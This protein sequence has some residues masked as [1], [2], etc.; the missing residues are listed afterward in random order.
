MF[1][2]HTKCLFLYQGLSIINSA[3]VSNKGN[4]SI[5]ISK[6]K[7]GTKIAVYAKDPLKNISKIKTVTVI[8]KTAPTIPK[9]NKVSANTKI[10]TGKA[11]SGAIVYI[12]NGNKLVKNGTVD[13]K[14]NIRI[15]IAKQKKGTA[16]TV[17][18][19]DKAGNKSKIRLVKVS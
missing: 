17:F 3:K 18:A 16:L 4:Y 9:I 5:N 8:D 14:G 19:K 11:E 7:A 1:D 6:Q 15:T 13:T 2:V 12:Y 10:L